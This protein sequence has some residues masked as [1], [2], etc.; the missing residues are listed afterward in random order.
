M[1]FGAKDL[2][3]ISYDLTGRMKKAPKKQNPE[4]EERQ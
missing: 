2:L 4:K 1:S 3:N